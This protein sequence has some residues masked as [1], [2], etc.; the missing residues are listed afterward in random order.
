MLIILWYLWIICYNDDDDVNEDDELLNKHSS[1]LAQVITW[2]L[3]CAVITLLLLLLA[4]GIILI[5]A[6]ERVGVA[7]TM[8]A[9]A[10]RETL[11]TVSYNLVNSVKSAYLI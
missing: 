9:N 7:V 8:S 3:S 4:F 5:V 1:L 6:N 11:P 10:V 2:S